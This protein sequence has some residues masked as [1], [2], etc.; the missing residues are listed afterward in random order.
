MSITDRVNPTLLANASA[1]GEWTRYQGGEGTL[2]VRGTFD[3][4]TV[5]LEWREADG[6]D[7]GVPV[8]S[9][10]SFTEAGMCSFKVPYGDLR[11]TVTGGSSPSGLYASVKG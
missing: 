2:Y 10:A 3:G 5:A 11:V 8:G 4:A 1:T 7:T 6:G 9:N